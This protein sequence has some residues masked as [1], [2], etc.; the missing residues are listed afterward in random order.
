MTLYSSTLHYIILY[1]LKALQNTT[2]H[3]ITLHN[4][5]GWIDRSSLQCLVIRSLGLAQG[6]AMDIGKA[7]GGWHSGPTQGSGPDLG[8]YEASFLHP[9]IIGVKHISDKNS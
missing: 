3:N 1:Y 7:Q 8:V 4:T 9:K 6:G 5:D 2:L